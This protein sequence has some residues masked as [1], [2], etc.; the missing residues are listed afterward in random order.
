M[1]SE[2]AISI[3]TVSLVISV[4]GKS[5][6]VVEGKKLHGFA[7]K[8]RLCDDVLLTS[9][10]DFYAKC[11]ELGNAAQLFSDIPHRN[12]IT[13]NAKISGF[14]QNGHI[15]EAIELFRQIEAAGLE[16]DAVILRSLVDAYSN[17]GVLQWG[18]VIHGYV[19][20]NFLYKDDNT[21]LETSI[22]NRN[23]RCGNISSARECFNRTLV[24]DIV[25]WTSMIEGY[26]IHGLGYEALN[27]IDQVVENGIS[28]NSVHLFKFI[29]CL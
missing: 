5:G 23:I 22:L 10:L 16:P 13:W 2:V 14:V 28:P 25:T 4:F 15:N 20:R 17:L 27:L 9:L 6:N 1:Q 11:G 8:A 29:I 7:I 18:K 21:L 19:I 24:R 12:N 3:E 26:A